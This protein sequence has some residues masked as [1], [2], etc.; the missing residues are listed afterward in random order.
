[1]SFISSRFGQFTYFN[2]QLGNPVWRGKRVLDFGG[3]VGNVLKDPRSTIDHQTYWCIDVSKQAIEEGGRRYPD[4]H[5]IFYDR[6]NFAF[7]PYGTEGLALPETGQEFDY[8]LAYSVFSHIGLTEM[9]DL[10]GQLERR[11]ARGGVLAFTFI[12]PHFNPATSNGGNHR[13]YYN[14]SCLKQR[15]ERQNKDKPDVDVNA[16]LRTADD[17]G[18]CILANDG[19]LYIETEDLRH[20]ERGE[21]R[22]FCAFYSD[23]FIKRLFAGA[24]VLPPPHN[25]YPASPEA[26]LQHCCIIRK[27]ADD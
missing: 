3:N 18:W 4:A 14:G 9:L 25:A 7:N 5:W 23:A 15:L 27:A 2:A 6:Y 13:E 17:A 21:K 11:L 10:I 24:T 12:D 8:I 26:V 16:I 20:Y 1:M 22:S 19:D